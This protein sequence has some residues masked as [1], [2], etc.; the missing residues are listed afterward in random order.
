MPEARYGLANCATSTPSTAT[1]LGGIRRI[2][3]ALECVF[4][5]RKRLSRQKNSDLAREVSFR[6]KTPRA[7]RFRLITAWA[8]SGLVFAETVEL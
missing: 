7:S 1:Y 2:S 6:V 8:V 4:E 5:R 3:I